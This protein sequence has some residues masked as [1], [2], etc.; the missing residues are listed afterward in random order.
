M[1]IVWRGRWE[2]PGDEQALASVRVLAGLEGAETPVDWTKLATLATGA[3]AEAGS[4]APSVRER[5]GE[6]TMAVSEVVGRQPVTPF[7]PAQ[8]GA[9]P[10]SAAGTPWG[11]SELRAAPVA[12]PGDATLAGP[13]RARPEAA[14]ESTL[15]L[16]PDQ[17]SAAR[18]RPV[19]PF[20]LTQEG[21]PSGAAA[22]A[23]EPRRSVPIAGAAWSGLVAPAAPVP[24]A[25]E[26][27]MALGHPRPSP[28]V[29]APPAM[30]APP[31][32]AAPPPA[33]EPVAA[34]PPAVPSPVTIVA[35]VAPVPLPVAAPP[36]RATAPQP[37][38][39]APAP[40]D[41]DAL[42]SQLQAAGANR[43]DVAALMR[44]LRPPPPP[45]P[46]EED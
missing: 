10:A 14:G 8:P 11:S 16:R 24:Q 2:V 29:V 19:A 12:S 40:K 31:P 34:P 32:I 36:P 43:D 42:A 21:P 37:P 39:R 30:V 26:S 13:A 3:P 23:G 9:A 44:A 20:A 18:E 15:G 17:Q 38:K 33:V 1:T 7:G 5:V 28:V 46:P 4:G 22:P 41:P 6:R 45:P 35:P 27:T 25:G